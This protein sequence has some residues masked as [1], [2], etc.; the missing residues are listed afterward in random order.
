[1]KHRVT[2][3]ENHNNEA[4]CNE[5][6]PSTTLTSTDSGNGDRAA[7]GNTRRDDVVMKSFH[8]NT[9]HVEMPKRLHEHTDTRE[10]S[11]TKQFRRSTIPS[12]R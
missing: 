6:F 5:M 4:T 7:H 11:P 8:R 9:G 12:E 2:S 3:T 10:D 1:M